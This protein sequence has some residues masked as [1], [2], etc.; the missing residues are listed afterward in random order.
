MTD[1]SRNRPIT[2]AASHRP[3]VDSHP[4]RHEEQAEQQAFERFDIDFDLVTELRLGQQQP[5]EEGA[6]RHGQAR[7][8]RHRS[9]ADDGQQRGGDE[10]LRAARRGHQPEQRP[11]R[12]PSDRQD[13]GDHGERLADGLQKRQSDVAVQP[14]A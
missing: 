6:E 12:Q 5:G 14:R 3:K 9:G 10:Q 2:E 8:S 11:Q 1:L 4:H 7:R 13:Q